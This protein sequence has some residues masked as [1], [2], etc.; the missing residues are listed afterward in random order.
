MG[1]ATRLHES[2]CQS[3]VWQSVFSV[4]QFGVLRTQLNS[5]SLDRRCSSVG[6]AS[7]RHAAEVVSILLC[8]DY[9]KQVGGQLIRIG[10]KISKKCW[11]YVDIFSCVKIN[12]FRSFFAFRLAMHV[13]CDNQCKT[14]AVRGNIFGT[15]EAI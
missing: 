9:S 12:V 1:R 10:L 3:V 11:L 7:N 4:V 6:T 15:A 5:P 2:V 13:R 8:S 14:G